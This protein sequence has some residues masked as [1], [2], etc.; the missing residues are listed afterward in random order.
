MQKTYKIPYRKDKWADE[1]RIYWPLIGANKNIYSASLIMGK[2]AP[3]PYQVEELKKTEW[4]IRIIESAHHHFNNLRNSLH[5]KPHN[6]SL[7][8][9]HILEPENFEKHINEDGRTAGE[10]KDGHVFLV[11]GKDR[12]RFICDLTH[13]LAHLYAYRTVL[14]WFTNE[15]VN[16]KSVHDGLRR[17][18]YRSKKGEGL[19]EAVTEIIGHIVRTRMC[20][21]NCGI[22]SPEKMRVHRSWVYLPQTEVVDAVIDTL[23]PKRQPVIDCLF[24]DY[25]CGT[26]QFFQLLY[27]KMPGTAAILRSM[28][29]KSEDALSTAKKLKMS[30]LVQR[31]EKMIASR[32][33]Q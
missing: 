4:E 18:F 31:I 2:P 8:R 17:N 7:D 30:D 1:V 12:V 13:E 27:R 6:F 29:I 9:F 10:C 28:G 19:N 16:Y 26:D 20:D 32:A 15:V 22:S 11:R 25:F 33:E 5:L 21:D 3:N 23:D 24:T 14:I